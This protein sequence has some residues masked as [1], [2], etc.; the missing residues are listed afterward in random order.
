MV[1]DIQKTY[2][3]FYLNV[4]MATN[5]LGWVQF[6]VASC[7]MSHFCSK[8]RKITTFPG[9]QDVVLLEYELIFYAFQETDNSVCHLT[10]ANLN[11]EEK[12]RI[13]AG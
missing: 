9:K 7:P 4:Y 3:D 11:N 1:G 10:P 13:L 12:A 6:S 5:Q 8:W 2:L